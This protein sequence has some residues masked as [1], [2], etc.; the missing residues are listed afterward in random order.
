MRKWLLIVGA[1][2]ALG[3]CYRAPARADGAQASLW[4]AEE[5][6]KVA[7]LAHRVNQLEL[8]SDAQMARI[9]ALEAK[10]PGA[11]PRGAP[12]TP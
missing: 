5:N 8:K 1:G 6:D 12:G 7:L 11:A 4:A 9:Q 3:G 2:L 10:A